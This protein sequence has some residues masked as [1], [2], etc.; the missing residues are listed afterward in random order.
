MLNVLIVKA[1]EAALSA[2]LALSAVCGCIRMATSAELSKSGASSTLNG[3][4][5]QNG[6]PP[7]EPEPE[8]GKARVAKDLFYPSASTSLSPAPPGTTLTYHVI[9]SQLAL[10]AVSF[11]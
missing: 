1:R 11:L 5:D 8:Q 3:H 2:R 7:A 4:K 9:T 10:L 6:S